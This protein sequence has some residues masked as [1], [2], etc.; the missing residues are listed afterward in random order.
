VAH[1][2]EGEA[3]VKRFRKANGQVWLEAANPQY[4]TI[5]SRS[6]KVIGRVVG[7]V[8]QFE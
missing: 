3:T 8:R 5:R 7:L 2:G 4:P 1:A 6:L